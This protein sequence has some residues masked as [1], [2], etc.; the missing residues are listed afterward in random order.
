MEEEILHERMPLCHFLI[1]DGEIGKGMYLAAGYQNFIEWQNQFLEP[2]TKAL[3]INK[4]GI[5]YYF[6]KNLKNR[7]DVQKANDND[8][9][10]KDFPD[11]SIYI[12]FL[13]LISLNSYRNIYYKNNN[14]IKINY[15][16]YNH[17]IYDFNIIE[18]ELGKILLTGKRLFNT[19]N[20]KFVTYCYEVF[21][22]EKSS[23][24]IDFIELY[25]PK[26]LNEEEKKNLIDYIIEKNTY[27]TYDFT[28]L[29]FSLQLIIYYLTQEKKPVDFTLSDVINSLPDYLNISD[30]CKSFC[31]KFYKFSV[32]QL[33][34]AFSIIEL[35]CFDI[36]SKNLKD[37]FKIDLEKDKIE[38]INNYFKN[39]VQKLIEK[40]DLASAC[41]KLISRY[42]ISKRSDNEIN[43][44]NLLS[45][46]LTKTDLWNLEIIKNDDLFEM[47][48]NN[49]KDFNITIS[50]A[51]KLC[52]LLDPDN[53]LLKEIKIKI[54]EKNKKTK[55]NETRAAESTKKKIGKKKKLK[56]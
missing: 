35:F 24:L 48:L 21:R 37:D 5:L 40:I 13:H 15:L 25:P 41:R 18:E 32:S 42:L 49:I 45:L 9:I 55:T 27:N 16:N 14:D 46:Y 43:P 47:E 39:G 36:I 10:K 50:Q 34:E 8:I 53:S 12:N 6:N 17:F 30:D 19:N 4:K 1:D 44:D 52:L 2:I 20:I 26:T 29:L 22:G 33:F 56:F 38:K 51:Y 11:N 54:E 23:T 7:I 3:D 31:E 28:Q